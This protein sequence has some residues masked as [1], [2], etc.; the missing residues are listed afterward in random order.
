MNCMTSNNYYIKDRLNMTFPVLSDNIQTCSTIYNSKITSIEYKD[1]I[2]D[3]VRIDI[4]DENI[5]E[6]NNIIET[7]KSGRRFE[8]KDYTNGNLNREI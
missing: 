2:I 1:F 3:S 8:G 6:I 5:K 4:L 7:V